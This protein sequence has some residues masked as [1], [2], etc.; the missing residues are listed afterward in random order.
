MATET[1]TVGEVAERSGFATSALRFYER[2]GLI[3]AERS[4]GGRRAGRCVLARVVARA[5]AGRPALSA[6]HMCGM[7]AERSG[8][9]GNVVS[10][11]GERRRSLA[12]SGHRSY[13]DQYVIGSPVRMSPAPRRKS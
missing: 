13:F 8:C 12:N 5:L 10:K 3:D 4:G 1:L 11:P 9:C 7:T 2:G 6:C